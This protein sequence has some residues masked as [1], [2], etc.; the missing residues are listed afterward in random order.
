M[1]RN[2]RSTATQVGED[3]TDKAGWMYA[4]LFLALMVIFLAT[5]S[6]VPEFRSA[7][8]SNTDGTTVASSTMTNGANF[9]YSGF[10][11]AKLKADIEKYRKENNLS[12][13][14]KI[15]YVQIIGGYDAAKQNVN[16]GTVTAISFSVNMKSAI[17]EL[18]NSADFK[19][20]TSADLAP[21]SVSLRIVFA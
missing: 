20:D 2:I 7:P 12:S 21:N 8:T 4:D 19:I 10:D 1:P 17:P 16:A 5:I 3:V 11:P 6:F 9:Q 18:F 15:V 14:A 13:I